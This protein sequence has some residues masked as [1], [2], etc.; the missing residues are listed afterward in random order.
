MKNLKSLTIKSKWM[1]KC[2]SFLFSIA[3]LFRDHIINMKNILYYEIISQQNLN[4]S[5]SINNFENKWNT[6]FS[7]SVTKFEIRARAMLIRRRF[8]HLVWNGSKHE[9]HRVTSHKAHL[10]C[11]W[12]PVPNHAPCITKDS[13]F[14]KLLT[15]WDKL[16][17]IRLKRTP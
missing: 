8:L 12:L 5:F 4:Q 7:C 17:K 10:N 9:T 16:G 2:L 14:F 11:L 13:F 3:Y 1:V 6:P 15:A